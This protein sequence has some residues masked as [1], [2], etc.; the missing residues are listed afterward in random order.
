MM[1]KRLPVTS[2]RA[3]LIKEAEAGLNVSPCK[4]G[5]V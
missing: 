5:A 4:T 2:E 3:R 1:D